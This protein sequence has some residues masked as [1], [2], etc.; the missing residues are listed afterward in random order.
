MLA[1]A[2]FGAWSAAPVA[3]LDDGIVIYR[4]PSCDYFLLETAGGIALLHWR[5]GDDPAVGHRVIGNVNLFQTPQFFNHTTQRSFR[6]TVEEYAQRDS[7][8][9]RAL[10]EHCP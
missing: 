2:A 5:L 3:A 7:T 4:Q 9:L 1:L 6:A 8:A 10:R